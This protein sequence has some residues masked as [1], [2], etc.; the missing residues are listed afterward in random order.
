MGNGTGSVGVATTD[1]TPDAGDPE[2]T[3]VSNRR[4]GH[5]ARIIVAGTFVLALA[6]CGSTSGDSAGT[7][8]ESGTAS[9]PGSSSTPTSQPPEHAF[10][11]T[12]TRTGGI[13]GFHDTLVL[14]ADGRLQVTSRGRNSSCRLKPEILKQILRAVGGVPW[15]RLPPASTKA[16]HPDDMIL[17]VTSGAS[18]GPARLDD[19]HLGGLQQSLSDLLVDASGPK[20]AHE[21]CQPD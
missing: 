15:S 11:I 2:A 4:T 10:P 5:A 13:A 6:A 16:K 17:L 9:G 20:P 3:D 14:Q 8:P 19:P 18:P 7:G 1:E 12:V 21:L